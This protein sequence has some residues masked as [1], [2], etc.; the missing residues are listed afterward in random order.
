M[1][2]YILHAFCTLQH[3]CYIYYFCWY[4]L[5][6]LLLA[7]ALVIVGELMLISIYLSYTDVLQPV[8][9]VNR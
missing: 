5:Y 9:L 6:S 2:I 8:C 7:V 3:Y 4:N 1:Y